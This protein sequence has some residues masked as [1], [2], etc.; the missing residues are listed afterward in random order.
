MTTY[1]AIPIGDVDQDSP[2]TQPL[3]TLLRDNPIAVTEAASGAPR[4]QPKA[5]VNFAGISTA[6][7]WAA[8]FTYPVERI[9]AHGWANVASSIAATLRMRASS[10]GGTTW[11]G[12]STL[13]SF[14]S[15][16]TAD[17]AMWE[18]EL[19]LLTGVY[20]CIYVGTVRGRQS[21]T[22]SVA[23][24]TNALQFDITNGNFN[25]TVYNVGTAT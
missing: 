9:R 12:Y 11:G 10:N 18:L 6:N 17:E 20:S 23:A 4:I 15:D 1:T 3:L 8:T 7:P 2:V 24:G 13:L 22:L 5:M 19:N 16:A 14:P 21:G 25:V